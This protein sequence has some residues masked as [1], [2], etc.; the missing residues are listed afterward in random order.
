VLS[1]ILKGQEPLTFNKDKQQNKQPHIKEEKKDYSGDD[2]ASRG[3]LSD[4]YS[5][6][7]SEG[8]SSGSQGSMTSHE[9]EVHDRARMNACAAL[10]HLSK[11]CSVSQKMCANPTI[12]H[13]LVATSNEFDS[14]LHTKSLEILA[15]LTRFPHNN[16]IMA[17]HAGL[18]QTLLANGNRADDTDRL[19]SMRTLQNLSSDSSAKTILATNDLLELLSVNIMRQK[20]EEQYAATA[21]LYN[22]STEPG[23]VVP[24]TNTKNVVATLVH[25][26]H[27]PISPGD[28]RL[29]ACDTLATLGLWLQTLA[30]AG[31]V[32]Q[33]Y[34]PSPLP[35]YV[36]AGWK[37]WD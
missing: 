6:N 30:G 21:A 36:T 27:N 8:H 5:S 11:E 28:I 22:I 24:L 13:C 12:L 3:I 10:M 14:P 16:A 4:S 33:G 9:K 32:P 2:E 25:V 17:T 23:A 18:V 19:W 15:N 7:S 34:E 35:T 29:M 26:A 37:R 31:T 1:I 20:Y